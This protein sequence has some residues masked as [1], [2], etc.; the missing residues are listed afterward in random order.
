LG[1]RRIYLKLLLFAAFIGLVAAVSLSPLRDQLS[2]ENARVMRDQ[3][4]S[5]WYGPPLYVLS[6]AVFATLLVPASVFVLTAGVIWGW[7][8]GT[9]LAICG[10]TAAAAASYWVSRFFG[11]GM[12][13]HFGRRGAQ[14]ASVLEKASFKSFLILRLL[15][16]FPFA[17]LNYGAGV[18]ALR[19]PMFVLATAIAL[20][21]STLVFTY[22][23]DALLSGSLSG[24]EALVRMLIVAGGV[25][26]LV[27]I[28]SLLKRRALREIEG[29][30]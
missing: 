20:L 9:L 18:A 23:A 1:Y 28:P 27:A 14:V 16:I 24:E 7:Q 6:F 21:P 29:T 5:S 13:R 8:F 17:V 3:L 2:V 11:G 12:L 15:P 19:F 25:A 22:S 4:A 26:V 10:G 30:D